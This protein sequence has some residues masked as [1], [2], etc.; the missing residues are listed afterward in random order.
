MLLIC[1]TFYGVLLETKSYWNLQK[2]S[3]II[4]QLQNLASGVSQQLFTL[5]FH[6]H[7][8]YNNIGSEGAKVIA[9][10]INTCAS[11]KKVDI[12][13]SKKLSKIAKFTV[14]TFR[15]QLKGGRSFCTTQSFR[16]QQINYWT[17]RQWHLHHL[18]PQ[19]IAIS[20]NSDNN[21]KDSDSA[22]FKSLE[23]NTIL[24]CLNLSD[25]KHCHN[26]RHNALFHTKQQTW[27][28]VCKYC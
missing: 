14:F 17:W 5:L 4:K 15:K 2:T 27:R 22:I 19:N 18:Q 9:E 1:S 23:K 28:R 12:S 6:F 16:V 26:I 11:L 20:Y 25:K 7:W 8:K 13:S 21:L 3:K 24:T 10:V